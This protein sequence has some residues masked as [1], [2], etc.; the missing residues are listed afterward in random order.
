M[1][2]VM[3]ARG[4]QTSGPSLMSVNV[5]RP[6]ELQTPQR[7]TRF[8]VRQAVETVGKGW[9][10]EGKIG[11]EDERMEFCL[12]LTSSFQH[13][14]FHLPTC[15]NLEEGKTKSPLIASAN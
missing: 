1:F 5:Q 14:C 8:G 11:E 15:Y 13:F 3:K 4:T 12:H 10:G 6:T 9:G 2:S 7:Q